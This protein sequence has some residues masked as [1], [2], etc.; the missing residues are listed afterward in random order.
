MTRPA[1]CLAM[2]PLLLAGC[3]MAPAPIASAPL[4]VDPLAVDPVA[5]AAQWLAMAD[6]PAATPATRLEALRGLDRMAVRT[7][8]DSEDN[9]VERWRAEAIGGGATFL[10]ER[11]RVLGPAY[12]SGWIEPGQRKTLEQL[13]MAGKTAHIVLSSP[14]RTPMALTISDPGGKTICQESGPPP[15]ECKWLALFT[16]RYRIELSNPSPARQRYF[17]VT[18]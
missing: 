1:L 2:A 8:P 10:P 3:S 7:L 18:N 13:F 9:P 5:R 15:G 11:G 16:Q 14:A 17:L 6:D 4:P 12:R